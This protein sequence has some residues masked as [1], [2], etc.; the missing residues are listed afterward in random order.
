MAI[1]TIAKDVGGTIETLF[2]DGIPSGDVTVTVY[3]DQGTA[4]VSAATAT[5]DP[6]ATTLSSAASAGATTVALASATSVAT[7]KRYRISSSSETEPDEVVTVKSVA[8]SVATLWGPIAY[9]HASGVSFAGIRVSYTI[10]SGAANSLW[11]DGWATFTPATG[12]P[13]SESIDCTRR[14]IPVDLIDESDLAK[15]H[16][17][18]RKILDT[19]LDVPSALRDARDEFL[20]DFGGKFRAHTA[21]A[22]KEF[23]RPVALKFFLMRRFSL[24]GDEWSDALD[25]MAEEYKYR[26]EKLQQGSQI[27]VD[28][29]Q[30]DVT[31][32]PDDGPSRA[33]SLSR[34]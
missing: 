22:F 7:G 28:A 33:I 1:Q 26:L 3:T 16:P 23:K 19:E 9:P 15:I 8:S 30:D 34:G 32:G 2:E 12:T 6:V 27:P 20:I 29:D 25:K 5:K 17:K 18:Y 11:W 31:S 24:T 4:K 21:I 10:T 14:V 13:V